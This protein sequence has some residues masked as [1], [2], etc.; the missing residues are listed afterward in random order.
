MKDEPITAIVIGYVDYAEEDRVV[1]L[2]TEHNGLVSAIAKKARSS[3][4]RFGG[5]IDIGNEI[6]AVISPPNQ[7]ELWR[8]RE[9][10]IAKG[11]FRIRKDIHKIA[12]MMYMCEVCAFLSLPDDSD[13]RLFGLLN[14]SL[15]LL[16]EAPMPSQSVHIGFTA[17]ALVFAGIHPRINACVHCLT[18]ISPRD[19]L[20][21]QPVLAGVLHEHCIPETLG[22]VGTHEPVAVDWNWLQ[23]AQE[24]LHRPLADSINREVPPGPHWVFSSILEHHR[25]KALRSKSF[26]HSLYPS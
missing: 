23:C 6:Q 11:R 17:K 1:K 21:F 13:S 9:A 8:L 24:I 15:L 4:R 26:L 5:A 14:A 20:F 12:L 16:A 3:H 2:L 22:L 18:G 19:K 10:R 25:E 7:G